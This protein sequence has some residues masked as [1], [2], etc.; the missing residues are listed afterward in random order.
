MERC[1]EVLKAEAARIP[2]LPNNTHYKLA[3]PAAFVS[4]GSSG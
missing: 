2:Y 4:S 1:I 3:Q